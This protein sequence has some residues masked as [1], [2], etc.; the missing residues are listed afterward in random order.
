MVAQASDGSYSLAPT[1]FNVYN[2]TCIAVAYL[3]VHASV[4]I[5]HIHRKYRAVALA[6]YVG[7]EQSEVLHGAIH[8]AEQTA[9]K[10]C[11]GMTVAVK[12]TLERLVA[13][14]TDSRKISAIYIGA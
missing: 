2:S 14:L 13:A 1:L 7:F 12:M 10:T 4:A 3:S 11:D 6:A 5:A 9:E 8:I